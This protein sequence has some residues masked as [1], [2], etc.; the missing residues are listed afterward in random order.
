MKK[1]LSVVLTFAA[2]LLAPAVANAFSAYGAGTSGNPYRIAT[3]AQLEEM[4]NDPA[5]HYVLVSNVDCH[6]TAFTAISSTFTGVLDG[7]NRTIANLNISG[8]GLFSDT[9]G[10]TIKNLT[11]SSGTINDANDV[12]SFASATHSTTLSNVHSEMTITGTDENGGLVGLSNDNLSISS[13]SY[14]GTITSSVYSGGLVGLIYDTGTNLITNSF[15]KGTF[16][17]VGTTFPEPDPSFD[18]GGLVG[19]MYGGSITN[20]YS[21]GTINFDTGAYVFGG[22]VGDT[23]NGVFNNDFAALTYSGSSPSSFGAAFGAFYT[24]GSYSSTRS[25][26]YYD[27]YLANSSGATLTCVG[28]DQG[29]GNCTAENVGNASPGYFKNNISNGPFGTWDFDGIWQTNANA[30]PTL[31]NQASFTDPAAPNSSDADGDGVADSYE[32]NVASTESGNSLWTTVVIPSTSSCTVQGAHS[33]A[34][35][36]LPAD[37]G[38]SLALNNLVDFDIYC[39]TAGA[40]VPVTLILNQQ[41]N[42]SGWVLRFYNT[43]THAYSTIPGVSFGITTVGG[44]TKTTVSYSTT[45]GG[46][47]DSDGSANGVIV[48]PVGLTISSDSSA[49]PSAPDTGFGVYTSSPW[50]PLIVS[51]LASTGLAGL[52]WLIRKRLVANDGA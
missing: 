26:I 25:N 40:T 47:Y 29:S 37:S 16:N 1:R 17:L 51:G 43:T 32:P 49:T 12:G 48:D 21:S 27:Q 44:V 35:N 52:G 41:Y 30:Y 28:F 33:L 50:T 6:G 24:G 3:C 34:S 9:S 39:P 2:V 19:L 7:Q 10:A 36:Q 18:N 46:P 14:S 11:I 8:S 13:S 42:T 20:S 22:L 38:Y 23:Y 4:Q 31:I 5:G 45:D 15:F